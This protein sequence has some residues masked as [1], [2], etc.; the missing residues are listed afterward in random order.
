MSNVLL[1]L[2]FLNW[3]TNAYLNRHGCVR[4]KKNKN[5]SPREKWCF[6]IDVPRYLKLQKV[7]EYTR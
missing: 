4:N 2:D 3:L 6:F 1:V 5:K 7:E